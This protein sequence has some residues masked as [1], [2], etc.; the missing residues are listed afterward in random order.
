MPVRARSASPP[1]TNPTSAL[2]LAATAVVLAATAL[3]P[4]PALAAPQPPP[5]PPPCSNET[6][7]PPPVDT[8]EVPPPGVASPEPLP[9]P[10][11][12]VGGDRLG[13][14]AGP[15]LPEGAPAPPPEVSAASWILA[16]VTSGEVL[17][18]RDSHARHRP[19]SAI[20]VLTALVAIRDLNM[21]DTLV[22]TQ[23]D[24]DQEGSRVGLHPGVTYTVEQV[25]TG[26]LM[27]S[28]NDAAHALA[29]KLGGPEVMTA[30]MNELAHHLGA[31]DTRAATPSGLDGPGMSSSAYDLALVF[32]AAMQ[33]PEFA[34]AI[35]TQHTVL[36][37]PPGQPLEVWSDNA[38]LLNYAGAL[39]GKTGFTDDA[40]HT[41]IAAAERDGRRIVAVLLRGENQP[42]RLSSQTMRLLDYGFTLRGRVGELV[43]E[44]ALEPTTETAPVVPVQ[45]VE[46]P[47]RDPAFGTVGGPL[48]LAAAAAVALL[49]VVGVRQR[50]ARRAAAARRESAKVPADHP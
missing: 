39:G 38:V 1:R 30:R 22:A 4:T 7:P 25:V 15:V 36:P 37:G 24:A 46:P 28:G 19:A 40:R 6:A 16:D 29:M 47:H 5:P 18:A 44:G 33:R 31:L 12:P 26:L 49:G 34:R 27:Q 13:E 2:R 8:S 43:A 9:V 20:K 48:T 45:N 10:E 21:S 17:A 32:R 11:K 42:L 50:R 35:N 14:C 3:G 41:F 23:A